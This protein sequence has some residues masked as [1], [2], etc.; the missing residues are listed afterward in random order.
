MIEKSTLVHLTKEFLQDSPNYL[1]EV[2]IAPSNKIT[3][4]IDNDRGV[5]IDDCVSLS[6]YIE[7]NLDRSIEDFELTVT[8]AGVTSP[9]K[10]LAQYKKYEGKEV[11]VLT[12]KGDKLKG[13]LKSSDEN[14][15]VIE[16]TEQIKQEGSKRK[17]SQQRDI[18]FTFDDIKYT[19]YLIRFK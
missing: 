4:E 6:Q 16:I 19:K 2:S 17:V 15:F 1:V 9:F 7:L 13:M 18:H 14:G 11:E 5:S 12:K 10:S 8:S 3:I